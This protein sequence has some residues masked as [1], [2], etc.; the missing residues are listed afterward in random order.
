[1]TCVV[2]WDNTKPAA[3]NQPASRFNFLPHFEDQDIRKKNKTTL[4]SGLF[5]PLTVSEFH[6]ERLYSQL[7]LISFICNT[8]SRAEIHL[9]HVFW[10]LLK[11]LGLHQYQ[12]TLFWKSTFVMS[13]RAMIPL[14]VWRR[15]RQAAVWLHPQRPR[16]IVS[17]QTPGRLGSLLTQQNKV[18]RKQSGNEPTIKSDSAVLLTATLKKA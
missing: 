17:F 12:E 18:S 10:P 14:P 11:L 13:Q 16:L 4:R 2:L 8:A 7:P 6:T 3:K 15:H 5:T 1:M 9:N